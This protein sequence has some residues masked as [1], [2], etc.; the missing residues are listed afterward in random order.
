MGLRQGKGLLLSVQLVLVSMRRGSHVQL[1][2]GEINNRHWDECPD[3]GL[4][5]EVLSG[6]E[7]PLRVV[8]ANETL[9]ALTRSGVVFMVAF[10]SFEQLSLLDDGLEGFA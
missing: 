6:D 9:E 5:G 10:Y 4:K 7:V 1:L 2:L 8:L 3:F